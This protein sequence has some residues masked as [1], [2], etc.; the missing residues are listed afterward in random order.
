MDTQAIKAHKFQGGRLGW[1]SPC[2][3]PECQL[4]HVVF[5]GVEAVC[6]WNMLMAL[7]NGWK[8]LGLRGQPSIVRMP[9]VMNRAETHICRLPETWKGVRV[10]RDAPRVLKDGVFDAYAASRFKNLTSP[11]TTLAGF[12]LL[13]KETR[14]LRFSVVKEMLG[15]AGMPLE[16]IIED[17]MDQWG[18][19]A[20]VPTLSSIAPDLVRNASLQEAVERFRQDSFDEE[21][22]RM[23]ASAYARLDR[24]DAKKTA[25]GLI[26]AAGI[27]L[28]HALTVSRTDQTLD[29]WH[30]GMETEFD[31][32]RNDHYYTRAI[33][34]IPPGPGDKKYWMF[35]VSAVRSFWTDWRGL[36]SVEYEAGKHKSTL[37]R[38]YL[39]NVY[40]HPGDARYLSFHG[41]EDTLKTC[42]NPHTKQNFTD[43]DA[44]LLGTLLDSR[45]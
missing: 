4:P 22:I 29:D 36:H 42:R 35:G 21:S 13:V 43:K 28:H 3:L 44:A 26:S 18:T 1:F 10:L 40:F 33:A 2:I 7:N 30:K 5:P 15:D 6:R 20:V 31:A 32:Y 24:Q 19:D 38:D 39:T 37:L 23:A 25:R 41:T 11:L 45:K 16:I 14:A 17:I 9:K 34:V 8:Y 12:E 27:P